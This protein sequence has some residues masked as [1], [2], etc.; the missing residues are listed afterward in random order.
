[1][2]DTQAAAALMV[3]TAVTMTSNPNSFIMKEYEMKF[4][5][6]SERIVKK[7]QDE[8]KPVPATRQNFNVFIPQYTNEGILELARQ[9]EKVRDYLRDLVN[10][11][12]AI[13]AR[14]QVT[15]DENPVN[16][17]SELDRSKLD[18]LYIAHLTKEERASASS[19]VSKEQ[20]AEFAADFKV[21]MQAIGGKSENFWEVIGEVLRRRYTAEAK[22]N[23]TF[24]AKIQGYVRAYAGSAPNAEQHAEVTAYLDARAT[25]IMTKED[26]NSL[27]ALLG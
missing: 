26:E 16:S 5:A 17:D 12:I 14:Y 1:M 18:L 7:L 24:M 20:L 8:G 4:K 22:A 10:D 9:D 13:H 3:A 2:S 23:P 21:A 27:A 6:P 19:T 15:A 25:E 11:A